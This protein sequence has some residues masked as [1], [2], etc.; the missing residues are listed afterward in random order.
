LDSL[1]SFAGAVTL[2]ADAAFPVAGWDTDVLKD[3]ALG[4]GALA[5]T[6]FFFTTPNTSAKVVPV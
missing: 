5:Q 3:G 6:P 2:A 4:S 1:P